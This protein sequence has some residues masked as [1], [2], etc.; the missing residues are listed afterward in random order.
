VAENFLGAVE[1]K[2]PTDILMQSRP[3]VDALIRRV[4]SG[5][6]HTGGSFHQMCQDVS[7]L[8]LLSEKAVT[9]LRTIQKLR[10]AAAHPESGGSFSEEEAM[11][12]VNMVIEII[13]E[14]H[15]RG[16]W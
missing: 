6:T 4:L 2:S 14:G 5:H 1:R 13:R 7:R 16:A 3:L 12:I 10:N 11:S 8:A 9:Y 15:K